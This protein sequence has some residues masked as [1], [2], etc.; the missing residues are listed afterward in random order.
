MNP[1]KNM[2]LLSQRFA[3]VLTALLAMET[4]VWL[5]TAAVAASGPNHGIV[6]A[7]IDVTVID[8]F[9][10]TNSVSF[11]LPYQ[12]GDFRVRAE[13][14]FGNGDYALQVGPE[15]TNDVLGGIMITS[16][17]QNGRDNF[18]LTVPGS[19]F[20]T[21]HIDYRRPGATNEGGELVENSYFIPVSVIGA[22]TGGGSE[23]DG[24]VAAAWFPYDTWIGGFARNN[25]GANGGAN[26][27]FTG[28]P[29]LV[30]GTHFVDNGSGRGT[31]NL[32]GLGIDAR[33]DGVL[34]VMGAKNED[35]YALSSVNPTNGTWH[36]FSKDN[37]TDTTS[38]EQDPF[39]FVYIP[40]S[41]TNVICGRFQ[42]NGTILIHS[43]MTPSFTISSNG[44]GEWELKIPGHQPRFGVLL[45]SPE[46]GFAGNQDNIVT[47]E[48]NSAGDG[49]IIQSR[50]LPGPASAPY[51][52]P[53][54][55]PGDGTNAVASFV[56]IPGPTPGVAVAPTAG[57]TTS[58]TGG[59]AVFNVSL[60]TRP[61][62]DVTIAVSSSDTT[63]GTVSP[64]S[65]T[66]T[67][68]DWNIPQTVTVTGVN[69]GLVDGPIGYTVVLAAAVSSDSDYS[70][71]NPA[72]VSVTNADDESGGFVVNP[73]SGLVTTEASGQASFTVRLT[74]Q[75]AA[76]VTVNLSSSD[77]TEGTIS[78]SSLTFT[79]L[80]WN[81]DQTN[82]ITGVDDFVD[83]GNIAYSIIT[84]VASSSDANYNGLNPSDVAALNQD[85][86]AAGFNLLAGPGGS[87]VVEGKTNTYTV[88]LDSQPTANVTVTVTSGNTAQGGTAS[89][90]TLTFTPGNWNVAQ[91]VSFIGA[92]D[93]IADGNTAWR[94]TNSISSTDP[95]Y[96]ALPPAIVSLATLDNEGVVTL[97][98]GD[99]RYGIGQS[100][101]GVD[102]RAAIADP[103]TL[104]YNGGTLTIT[105][106]ANGTADDRLEIRNT[107]SG[108]GQIG[109]SGAN[110]TY[111]GTTIGSFSG[112]VGISPLVVTLNSSATPTAT[113]ALLRNVT[114]R[115]VSSAPS[116]S[117]R[118]VSV[119]LARSD[120]FT[121]SATT[122]VRVS[123]VRVA[124]F[125]QD[126]D[127]G[128]GAYTNAVDTELYQA[129]PTT[130]LPMGH[131]NDTNNPQMWID[132]RDADTPNQSEVLLRFGDIVGNGPGQ[133]PANAIVVSAELLLNVRDAGD[134][135]PLYRMLVPWDEQTATW[136][137]LVDGIQPNDSEARST[138]ESILGVPAVSGD[139]GLGVITVGV[140]TDV[141]AWVNGT[142]NY[143]WGMPSW[144]SEINPSWGNGTDG[145][146]FRVCE[147]P[148]IDDR[149][150]LRVL[151]VP[152]NAVA[153][154]FRQNVNG[155][156]SAQ[157]TRI[158]QAEPDA[159]GGTLGSAFV[160][161]IALGATNNPD[162]LLYRFDNIFGANPGQIPPGSSV[163]AAML[164]LATVVG[165]GYGD[166]GLFYAMYAPWLS[167]A[168]WNSLGNGIQT[169]GVEAASTSTTVIGA[170]SLIPNACGGYMSFE[171]TP[172]VQDWANG[173]R[174]NNGWAV[175][176]WPGGGDGWGISMSESGTVRDRPQLRVFFTPGLYMVTPIVSA[177]SVQVQFTGVAGTSCTVWRASA[178]TGTYLSIGSTTI[179]G[180]GTGSITD[181]APLP[182]AAFYRVSSP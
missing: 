12:M 81:Q 55:T 154:S 38:L 7:N 157:D 43:G 146:G 169:D 155:Y 23:Y 103:Y 134:G 27:L 95:S 31:V 156:T 5:P 158:R 99:L 73:T 136:D 139:T 45:V 143:G 49:W 54:E 62:N 94:I 180:G 110:V 111:G 179:G 63:E 48:V 76:N 166:G 6:A 132:Y 17:R 97:P 144:N 163:E 124:D 87:Q 112:G 152:T 178:V 104:N 130:P 42:G 9:N 171:T 83:D 68:N 141:Q 44:I 161:A 133:I 123:L 102:G 18:S 26:N 77:T 32:T 98:S 82:T 46:G 65:L 175:L 3:R 69:D 29:G 119:T 114:F 131:N 142:N 11:T 58:E 135:S 101:V 20:Y 115:S 25:T 88:A 105:L 92:D 91:V 126:A 84:G 59:Q 89:P 147:S 78:P 64:S 138:Y 128:Y 113:E 129:Q 50:D 174:P 34:L 145:L 117:R 165:N 52:P 56:F 176:P 127:R 28:S 173:T 24:N 2:S 90:P 41:D 177:G 39:A 167:T 10:V 149:P 85:N 170:A 182:G 13:S 168:T 35:N 37:G 60:D 72:D 40:K 19:N 93:L 8:F 15:C 153:V 122:G 172:D 4:V 75:P 121:A 100:G 106:T 51:I 164:D 159:Q 36:L 86:D 108:A 61:T 80:N 67:T 21:S 107:G 57:L 1:S 150:R 47:Y 96:A 120:T 116:R 109:V 16:V 70:G 151:W 118:S 66:F 160:D 22:G 140:T 79:P 33:T 71:I 148:S 125:Q 30:L 137:G 181:N 14:G 53:L 74:T 162:I